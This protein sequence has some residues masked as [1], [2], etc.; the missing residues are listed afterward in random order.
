MKTM[1]PGL[2]MLASALILAGCATEPRGAKLTYESSPLGQ[3]A[4]TTGVRIWP[5]L[6]SPA[7]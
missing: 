3:T 2:A 7:G 1:L 4:V 6:R 5:S